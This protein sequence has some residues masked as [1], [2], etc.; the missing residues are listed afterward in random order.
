[1]STPAMITLCAWCPDKAARDAAAE[2]AGHIVSHGICERCKA[3]LLASIGTE[4]E[5]EPAATVRF[6]CRPSLT[7]HAL[8]PV[9][10]AA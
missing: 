9:T 2:S 3:A 5:P 4:I 8:S 1:M 7:R 10:R 6:T